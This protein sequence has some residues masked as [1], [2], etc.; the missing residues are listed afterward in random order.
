MGELSVDVKPLTVLDRELRLVCVLSWL[1]DLDLNGC[2]R[3][4]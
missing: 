3:L 4:L 1:L 2:S